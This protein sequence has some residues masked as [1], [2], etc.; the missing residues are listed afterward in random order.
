MQS[1]ARHFSTGLYCGLHWISPWLPPSFSTYIIV[2]QYE[3][4]EI[5][6]QK[7]QQCRMPYQPLCYYGSNLCCLFKTRH[8]M[9]TKNSFKNQCV[10]NLSPQIL[11]RMKSCVQRCWFAYIFA[12]VLLKKRKTALWTSVRYIYVYVLS[13]MYMKIQE[14]EIKASENT[15]ITSL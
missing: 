11:F 13:Q 12:T 8:S 15:K 10:A 1:H 6:V 9:H 4:L 5:S 3:Q 7:E 2:V 14:E